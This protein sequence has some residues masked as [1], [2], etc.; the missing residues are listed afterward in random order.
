[1]LDSLIAVDKELMLAINGRQNVVFDFIMPLLSS[2]WSN[3]PLLAS[4]LAFAWFRLKRRDFIFMTIAIAVTFALTDSLSVALF[5]DTIQRFRPCWDPEIMDK[6]RLLEYRGGKFGF[7]SSHAANLFGLAMITLLFI[8]N[9]GYA[10]LIFLWAATV[11]FSRVYV[12]KHFP[13]DVIC[14]AIFG[15][16]IG[17]IV[18]TAIG[19]IRKHACKSNGGNR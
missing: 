16:L 5:K 2:K 17:W 9:R 15:L 7:I 4:I 8:R 1:M 10:I 13:G 11:G 6:V 19:C 18:Y 3:V 14:G 12:G